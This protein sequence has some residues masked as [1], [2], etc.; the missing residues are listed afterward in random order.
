LRVPVS[1]LQADAPLS[2][3]VDSLMA[4][5]L[6]TRIESDLEVAVPVAAF[7]DG[8]SAAELA[9]V[10]LQEAAPESQVMTVAEMEAE[11]VLP[12]EIVP[13]GPPA[14]PSEP[15]AVLLTGATGFLGAFL[16]DE[17]LAQTSARIYCLVRAA[18]EEQAMRRIL[19]NGAAYGL[20]HWERSRIVPVPGDLSRALLGLPE[21][22]YAQL[23][24]G[25]DSIY[26]N[27]AAVKWTYPYASLQSHNVAGTREILR[28]SV[29]TRTKPV[30]Y[31]STIGVF[32]SP[33]YAGGIV[34]ESEELRNSGPLHIGYAQTKWIAERLVR[35]AASRG[36]PVSIYRPNVSADSRTG[37]F[38]RHDHI[39]MLIKGCLQLGRAPDWDLY[40]SGA[41][42]DY[43]AKALVSLSRRSESNGK[44][45][46]LVNPGGMHWKDLVCWM[47][48][49]GYQV[50]LTNYEQ[51]RGALI[52]S[53]RSPRSN[54]LEGLSPFFSES[55]LQHVR[56][57]VFDCSNV[58]RMLHSNGVVCP[59]IG[60][61][62][63]STY[64]A[65]FRESGFLEGGMNG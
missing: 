4:V 38:N 54:A 21:Q 57:P 27:G 26:H 48:T 12:E 9:E 17:L 41:P 35:L 49:H 5:E 61:A 8:K 19:E 39:C 44:T 53:L 22:R 36:M 59:P 33:D 31:V 18:D 1:I 52:A 58:T 10:L 2:S 20:N 7:F 51:W 13:T 60:D 14:W 11:A 64:F 25:I 29:K 6:K 32:S 46:H 50:E 47:A 62:L 40:L 37:A 56:L 15:E 65:H 3:Q 34:A 28:L 23:A 30:H 24:D 63:L 16:V 42:A 43:V 55:A 45:Y